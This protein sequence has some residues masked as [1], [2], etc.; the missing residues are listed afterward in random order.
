[1]YKAGSKYKVTYLG[2]VMW[3]KSFKDLKYYYD[4]KARSVFE[5]QEELKA[6]DPGMEYPIIEKV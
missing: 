6:E 4:S 5:L 3:F 1:M 2:D